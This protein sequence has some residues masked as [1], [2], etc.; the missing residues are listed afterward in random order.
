M[1]ADDA[2]L[3]IPGPTNLPDEVREALAQPSIYHRGDEA[4]ALVARC[5]IASFRIS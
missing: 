4:A 5:E 1:I 2:L 3:M